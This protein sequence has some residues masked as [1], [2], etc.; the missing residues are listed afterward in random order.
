MSEKKKEPKLSLAAKAKKFDVPLGTL[1]KVFRRGVAAWNSGHRPGTTPQQW[2]H[3]RVNSYLRKGKTYHTADKDLREDIEQLDELKKDTLQS[4][5]EKR[6]APKIS[7]IARAETVGKPEERQKDIERANLTRI[8]RARA[9][10]KLLQIHRAENP[11]ELV[12]QHKD[13]HHPYASRVPGVPDKPGSVY[14]GDHVEHDDVNK[15]FEK[16]LFLDAD[17]EQAAAASELEKSGKSPEQIWKEKGAFKDPY[18]GKWTK[19]ISDKQMD[20]PGFQ[21]QSGFVKSDKKAQTKPAQA[22]IKH[23]ELFKKV[24]GVKATQ[25]TTQSVTPVERIFGKLPYRGQYTGADVRRGYRPPSIHTLTTSKKGALDVMAHELQHNVDDLQNRMNKPKYSVDNFNKSKVANLMRHSVDPNEIRANATMSRRELDDKQ[26]KERFPLKDYK[27]GASIFGGKVGVPLTMV[28]KSLRESQLV[29]TDEYRDY[30][31]AMTPGQE[32]E[33]QD[34]FPPETYGT[35][36]Y[37]PTTQEESTNT[38]SNG[39]VESGVDSTSGNSFRAIR[40]KLEEQEVEELEDEEQIE[41]E[42]EEEQTE[43]DGVEDGVDFTPNLKTTKAR[44][45]V[46][47]VSAADSVSGFPVLG[48]A[49]AVEYHQEND[50]SLL[51][52]IFRPGSDM[53]FAMI[54]EAKRLYAEGEYT[55]QDEYEQ[56]LLESDIGEVAEYNGTPVLLDFPYEEI[57]EELDEACWDGYEQKGMKKKGKKMVPNCVPVNEE[58]DPTHGKGI[59]KPFRSRGGGAVYVRNAKG[60]VIKVNFSQSGMRKRFNEPARVKSFVARHNCYGNKDKTSASYWACRWPRYFSNSG[61][62]WW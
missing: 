40:K 2:G 49:E 43:D 33:I 8:G 36:V 45:Y 29:G 23:D 44:R 22:A 17:P 11:Q 35:E 58:G 30:A 7:D 6:R 34:A 53:F 52:N 9:K 26:R 14:W 4:Y 5:L 62:Q 27:L 19:E 42:E 15:L 51:E 13:M 60:N 16:L 47:Q 1:K 10:R 48:I 46:P 18:T 24:P 25:V 38:E 56:D 57:D 59:G 54:L 39:S 55:P 28:P 50:I 32:Q 37:E 20:L 61:Q 21:P 3:A 12:Q 41:G 31:L